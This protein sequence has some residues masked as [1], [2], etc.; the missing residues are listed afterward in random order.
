M[1]VYSFDDLFFS[2]DFIGFFH[3]MA[4][5]VGPPP[6]LSP[7]FTTLH[8]WSTLGPYEDLFQCT[9]GGERMTSHDV[10]QDNFCVYHK[11]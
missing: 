7:W 1:V 4:H 6:P 2:I 3:W 11:G 5:S 8:L 9:H 10:V